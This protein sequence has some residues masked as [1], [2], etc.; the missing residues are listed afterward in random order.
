MKMDNSSE[1]SIHS[2]LCRVVNDCVS[3]VETTVSELTE[4][5]IRN[6]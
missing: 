1:K 6:S 2:L 4:E 3:S 5:K